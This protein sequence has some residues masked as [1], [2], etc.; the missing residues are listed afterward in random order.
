VGIAVT[1][2]LNPGTYNGTNVNLLPY[3]DGTLLSTNKGGNTGAAASFLDDGGAA[4]L[5]MN[6]A[7]NGNMTSNQYLLITHLYSYFGYLLGCSELGQ[8]GFP[9]Y[10]GDTSMGNVHKFMDLN[11]KQVGYFI[12]QVGTAA[13][14]F[15]V[16]SDDVMTVGKALESAFG[17]RCAPA[18]AIP[19]SAPAAL[20]AICLDNSCPESPN[21]TC[22]AYGA[23]MTPTFANGTTYTAPGAASGTATGSAGASMSASASASAGAGGSGAASL[24][25]ISYATSLVVLAALGFA[26]LM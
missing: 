2:I 10:S 23:V 1:G 3:F 21:A 15:G 17:Y 18:V 13:A 20:Q 12:T 6:K 16:T 5:K 11:P 25:A 7:S 26:V 9:A 4:P 14:S 19:S 24:M 22:A 8:M